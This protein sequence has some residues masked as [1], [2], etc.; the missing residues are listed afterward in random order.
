MTNITHE[1]LKTLD[2][3]PSIRRCMSQGLINTTALAK[4]II[5]EKNID[6]TLDAV[7][8]AI[9]RYKLDKYD[10]IFDVANRL[11]TFGE[12]STKSKLAN[13]AVIKDSEVQE[14]L[15]KL[16]SIIQFNRGD[17]LRIIQ[18]D[19][20]IKILVNEKN[21]DKVKELLPKKK[22]I[23]IDR[24]LAELNIHLHPEAVKTPG[25]IAIISN[26]LALNNINVMEFM[27]CVPEMLWFVK[28]KDI[29]KAHNVMFR[30]C[31]PVE[32]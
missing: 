19:E 20:A 11:V 25:I 26:E 30:L 2:N 21:L 32:G 16:F 17:A 22:I 27:S 24:N 7:S 5:K 15:P 10:E 14:L 12:I 29:L 4:Y 23:K 18:A 28:E 8:S 13:I 9:R 6:A 31:G 3:N 1:V